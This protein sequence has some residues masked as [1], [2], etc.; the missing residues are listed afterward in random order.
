MAGATPHGNGPC[1]RP[2]PCPR[3]WDVDLLRVLSG[4]EGPGNSSRLSGSLPATRD[5]ART[6]SPGCRTS[7]LRAATCGQR[8][9]SGGMRLQLTHR[10][11]GP[12]N[13]TLITAPCNALMTT[14]AGSVAALRLST[15]SSRTTPRSGLR[16]QVYP[17]VD[18]LFTPAGNSGLGGE[19]HA[20]RTITWPLPRRMS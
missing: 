10:L 17:R 8:R 16:S 3:C 15:L 5:A 7:R 2:W 13:T 11:I 1:G 19:R 14:F 9:P 4:V 12:I 20:G 18:V 6:N